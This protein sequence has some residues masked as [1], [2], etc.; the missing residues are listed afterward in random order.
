VGTS[1]SWKNKK[2]GIRMFAVF[3]NI[4]SS[5]YI[6]SISTFAFLGLLSFRNAGD[7][8][9]KNFLPAQKAVNNTERF[10]YP[11]LVKKFYLLNCENYF[12][13]GQDEEFT[14]KRKQLL[15]VI[16][17]SFYYGLI[18]KAYHLQELKL[19]F[20][21]VVSDSTAMLNA[22]KLFT[23]AA[24][25][26]FKDIYQGYK[27]K[28]WVTYDQLSKINAE[29]DNDYL[30][31]CLL[32]A[33]NAEKLQSAV[34]WLEPSD[35][36]YLVLKNELKRLKQKKK[37]D[38]LTYV[39][40]AMNMYRWIH[41]FHFEKKIV[42]NVPATRLSYYENDSLLLQMKTVLG[43]PSTPTPLFAT[44]CDEAILYPYWYVPSSIIFNEFL[45]LIKR[46]PSWIDAHNMQVVDGAGKVLNHHKLNWA[47]FHNGYFPYSIRQSTGCDNALGVIKFNIISPFGV[48]LHDTNNKTAFLSGYRF[49][50][51]GCIRIQ[52]PLSLGNK[53]LKNRLDTTFL[54]S[55]FKEQKSVPVK[56]DKPVPVFVVYMLAETVP[57]S[58][59]KYYKDI[60]RLIK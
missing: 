11:E 5:L 4:K 41:H 54:Q 23:D 27:T 9:N 38:S 56:L 3:K 52:E 7:S 59:V 53:L 1:G 24:I 18:A 19:K 28:A 47:A 25:A 30:L 35:K 10:I 39:I 49:F 16:D 37:T 36:D 14:A 20:E 22:D 40:H 57:G 60:Y 12:W 31:Q 29:A 48:Y 58:K 46:N 34:E 43:K 17:S 45:P 6:I 51:H 8:L 33:T 13:Y 55:C 50:S 26:V 2:A 21:T 32:N 15:T 44:V 42:V